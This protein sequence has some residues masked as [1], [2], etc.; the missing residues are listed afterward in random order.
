MGTSTWDKRTGT[1]VLL[2]YSRVGFKGAKDYFVLHRA[3][4]I[5]PADVKALAVAL[6]SEAAFQATVPNFLEYWR[7][8]KKTRGAR[9]GLDTLAARIRKGKL[10]GSTAWQFAVTP[11]PT[12]SG[13]NKNSFF[14]ITL[15]IVLPGVV[16]PSDHAAVLAGLQHRSGVANRAFFDAFDVLLKGLRTRQNVGHYP[17]AADLL[18]EIFTRD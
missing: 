16:R 4:K 15:R 7:D 8:P 5:D 14:H 1:D 3:L 13:S 17:A 9:H 18:E 12:D 6:T 2:H 11:V 10:N